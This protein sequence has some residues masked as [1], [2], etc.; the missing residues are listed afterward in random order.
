MTEAELKTLIADY[1][2]GTLSEADF[3]HLQDALRENSEGRAYFRRYMNLDA[4]LTDA[5]SAKDA[6]HNVWTAPAKA[7]AFTSRTS[8]L[9]W[10][11]AAAAAILALVGFF[12]WKS[13]TH[14][15]PDPLVASQEEVATGFAILSRLI[16]AQWQDGADPPSAGDSLSAGH[17]RLKSG[18]AQIEFFSGATVLLEGE[19]HFEIVSEQRARCH[20]GRLRATVPPA[21]R[22]FTIA[23]PDTEVVDLGTEIGIAVARNGSSEVHVIAGEVEL[24]TGQELVTSLKTGEAMTLERGLPD[25]RMAA[26]SEAFANLEALEP[27]SQAEDR[28]RFDRWQKYSRQLRRDPRLIVY[29]SC[30]QPQPWHRRLINEAGDP[31]RQGALVGVKRTPGRWPW[32]GAVEFRRPGDRV[33][34]FIPG[35]YSSLTLACWVRLDSVARMWNSL[36]L[37]DGYEKGEVHWQVTEEGRL[38]YSMRIRE[39]GKDRQYLYLSPPFWK[40]ELSGRWIHL[41]TTFDAEK[42]EVTHYLDGKEIHREQ[43]TPD[44]L[45][46]TTRFGAGEI[47]NWGQSLRRTDPEFVIRSLNGLLDEFAIFSGALSGAEIKAMFEAGNPVG[48]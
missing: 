2:N 5:A 20:Y 14:P 19:A 15:R 40:S 25:H 21:A 11:P 45:V 46:T 12:L 30:D 7:R 41:A 1:C 18:V 47:G 37:T 42:A 22:G 29:Y 27:Q 34:V 9:V 26:D 17:L 35:D 38:A 36:Y 33:R 28:A 31:E 16:D 10:A 6:E 3:V 44:H 24:H 43:S 23:T 48:P 13:T 4:A 32:K 8:P 39:T